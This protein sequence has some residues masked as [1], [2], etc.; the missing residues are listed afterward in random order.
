MT[1][2]PT[3]PTPARLGPITIGT[4]GLGSRADAPTLATAMLTSPIGQIDTSNTYAGGESERTLGRALRALDGFPHG[5]SIF[6]KADADPDTGVFDGDR[7]R[8]SFAETLERLG[9]DS[10]PI[11]HLH[12]P[13]SLSVAEAFAPGGAVEALT[14][15]RDEGAVGAIGI[16]A[17]PVGL[18]TEYVST[19]VFDA[20]LTHNRYTLAD[21]TA[22]PLIELAASKGMT[23]FNAAPFGGGILAGSTAGRDRYAYRPAPAPLLA[24]IDRVRQLCDDAGVSVAA[25]AL[26]FSTAHPL[27]DST[28]VGVSS[29]AWLE[30]LSVLASTAIPGG[31]QDAI[32]ALGDPPPSTT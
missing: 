15:L 26:N 18:M 8:R 12:D 28:V 17:G 29:L 4:S 21:R 24:Y 10:L 32:A 20:M 9:V 7:V 19:G 6:S 1:Q 11:Y 27:I 2:S 25:A 13:Y 14:A 16:A 3:E 22:L 30:Q 23:V 31:L 5:T